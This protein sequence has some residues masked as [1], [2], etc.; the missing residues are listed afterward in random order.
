M[1]RLMTMTA[2]LASLTLM[3]CGNEATEQELNVGQSA[4]ALTVGTL[5]R[6]DVEALQ[7]LLER[8]AAGELIEVPAT[9]LCGG[10]PCPENAPLVD[11][12]QDPVPLFAPRAAS[13]MDE[14]PDEPCGVGPRP[15]GPTPMPEVM[16]DVAAAELIAAE[17]MEV[18]R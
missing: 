9:D 4:D 5:E 12:P 13:A 8:Y 10:I 15:A 16:A 1:N 18:A 17:E 2:A 3:A 14:S 6:T 7:V 11:L